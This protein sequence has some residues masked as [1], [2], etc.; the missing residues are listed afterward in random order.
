MA[1]DRWPTETNENP[2]TKETNMRKSNLI[3]HCGARTVTRDQ[4]AGVATP[5][6]TATWVPVPHG[7]LLDGVQGC[8]ERAGLHVVTEAHG[9][10][11]EGNRYFGLLQVANGDNPDDFGLVVGLRNSHDQSFPACLAVGASVFVCDN[12]SFSGEVKLARKHTAH[13]ER[14][15][16]ALI[17]RAV[18]PLGDLRRTQEARFTAYKGLELT[19]GAAHD[20]VVRALD[21]R[22]VPVTRIPAVLA[23]WRQPRHPE[24]REGRTAWRLFNA[25]TESLKGNLDALPARTQALHGLLDGVCGLAARN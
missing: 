6:R 25:F 1:A 19:D 5:A 2:N 11:R 9:L 16:P 18:G 8:L 12:L 13:V 21:A 15:L 17:E 23:E 22:V 4:V 20:L 10:T 7:R 24:F 14:D 3:L